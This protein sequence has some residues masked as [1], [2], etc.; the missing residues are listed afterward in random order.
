[1][2]GVSLSEALHAF[3]IPFAA[4]AWWGLMG[5]SVGAV[6][7]C[8]RWRR[9]DR[10][11]AEFVRH[12]V[13]IHATLRADRDAWRTLARDAVEALRVATGR[14]QACEHDWRRFCGWTNPAGLPKA[15][16]ICR[17][18]HAERTR[19]DVQVCP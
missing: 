19:D 16:D 8:L 4:C 12:D 1:M 3:A 18:C 5:F 13:Q 10:G 15:V 14:V 7:Q 11:Y 6:W 9:L 17:R 2:N